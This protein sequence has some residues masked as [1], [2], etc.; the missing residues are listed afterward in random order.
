MT[1][2]AGR[3]DVQF[4]S[5]D[6]HCQAWL[7]LPAGATSA[8]P[9]PIIVMA[10]GFAGIK[11]MRLDAFAERFVGQG[12]ACLVFDYRHFGASTGDPRE[13]VNVRRELDD[14]KNAVAYARHV[15]EADPARVILWGTSFAGGH[16]IVTAADDP[17]IAATIAQCPFTDGLAAGVR[18][19]FTTLLRLMRCAVQDSRAAKRG[20]DPVR[21]EVV[22]N[23][24]DLAIMTAP[25]SMPGFNA[26]LEAS[27][28]SDW[29]SRVPARVM[30]QIPRY[31]P[32]RRAK[33]IRTPILF[34]ICDRDSVTPA[35][36]TDKYAAQAVLSETLHYD[37][38]HFE[39]YVGDLFETVVC[40]Q[41]SFLA[42]HVPTRP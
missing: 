33:D 32:G 30:F 21:V 28:I 24:G 41:I 17:D 36:K 19:P 14:W 5:G 34:C 25:D 16:V 38:G 7:Y 3:V 9:A 10:H 31:A 6:G 11:E 27:G 15:P 4:G 18:M 39:I 20:R 40:D 29:P 42:E 2:S 8:K 37:A 12:Y 1:D 26:I 13:L 35:R 23:P 22:G